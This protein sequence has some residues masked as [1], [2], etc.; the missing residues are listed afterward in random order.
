[1]SSINNVE[2]NQALFDGAWWFWYEFMIL[3]WGNRCQFLTPVILDSLR[4]LASLIFFFLDNS[5]EYLHYA[6]HQAI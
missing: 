2:G 3:L 6:D 1:M 4:T 5:V